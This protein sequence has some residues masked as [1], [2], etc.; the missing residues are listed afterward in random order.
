STGVPA[1][2]W[3]GIFSDPWKGEMKLGGGAALANIDGDASGK[4]EAVLVGIQDRVGEDR[5]YY[6][7]AWNLDGTGKASSWSK[8]LFGPY[9][10]MSQEG[11]G[12][13]IADIDRNGIP[14]LLLMSVDDPDGGNSFRYNIGWNMTKDGKVASWS[15]M[16]QGPS[17]GNSNSGGGAA[18]GDID[19]NG[20][21]DL[22]L[23]GVDNP[24]QGN[25]FWY[26]VGKNLDKT[27]KPTAWTPAINAPCYLGWSS[28]GGGA[29][30]ADINGNGKLDLV[31]SGIDSPTGANT[32]W[33]YVGWDI[34]INGN[35]TGWSPKFSG[36][37]TG[38]ISYGGGTAVGDINKNGIMDMLLMTVDNPYG[39]D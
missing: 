20:L 30:L 33:C 1:R 28:A 12:A 3:S 2:S 31:L 11:G 5:F 15:N 10:A 6:K 4:Y 35:V 13:D 24:E 23:M 25:S 38:N 29:A 27:G 26:C 19:K 18:L 34:D 9:C 17:I 37:A 16:I 21:P 22:V 8:T 7:V 36:P 32:F 14:D 39:K